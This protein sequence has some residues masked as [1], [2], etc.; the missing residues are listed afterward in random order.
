MHKN[1]DSVISINIGTTVK[2]RPRSP[3]IDKPLIKASHV[4]L[5]L[6]QIKKLEKIA[7]REAKGKRP[8]SLRSLICPW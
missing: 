2:I 8:F 3:G 1:G 6:S 4:S 5:Y 7:Q